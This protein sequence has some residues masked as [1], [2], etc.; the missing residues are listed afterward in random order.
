MTSSLNPPKNH[1][2]EYKDFFEVTNHLATEKVDFIYRKTMISES[3][4]FE[5]GSEDSL[6]SFERFD[7]EKTLAIYSYLKYKL[8]FLVDDTTKKWYLKNIRFFEKTLKKINNST[9]FITPC[10]IFIK[11]VYKK[12]DYN[13]DKTVGRL[14]NSDSINTLP[15]EIR[16]FLFED[17]YIDLDIANAHPSLLYL[18]SKENNLTLNGSLSRYIKN[19]T[20]VM[21]DIQEESGMDLNLVKK[22]VLKLLNKT[23]DNKPLKFS[24]TL[25]ELDEDFQSIRNHLWASYCK[26]EL[27]NYEQPIKQSMAKKKKVYTLDDGKIN[28]LKLLNLKK[29]SLQSFFCQTQESSHL[30]KLVKFLRQKYLSYT[31][32]NPQFSYYYPYTDKRVELG[33]EHTLFV[34]P[35]F[36][37]LY[38]SSPCSYFMGDV[39]SI[40]EEYNKQNNGVVFVQ[41]TIEQRVEYM[42]DTNELKKFTIINTWLGRST[43]KYYLDLLLHKK[44]ISQKIL[45]LLKDKS[46]KLGNLTDEESLV[47]DNSYKEIMSTIKFEVYKI[48]LEHD[49][50]TENDI[51]KIILNM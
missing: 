51:I 29:V 22:N 9:C 17:N 34:I 46:G 12:I 39:S 8:P 43:T 21:V 26:G 48:L 15:R 20:M 36:D 44:N 18:Y 7:A 25:T 33:A 23:W 42:P 27:K 45:D 24:Q 30:I 28:E 32:E 1:K 19:R 10:D 6:V 41:K 11:Q 4:V 49:I 14:Y 47:W 35:F 50:K 38:L 40:I 2:T 13:G 37:G 16:Y 5:K 31:K 3:N